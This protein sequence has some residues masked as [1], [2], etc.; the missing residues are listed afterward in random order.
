MLKKYIDQSLLSSLLVDATKAAVWVWNVQTGEVEFNERWAEIIGYTL[1]EL[2]PISINTWL[3]YSNEEDLKISNAALEDVFTHK[4]S[5]YCAEVRMRH[6][7]G[8]WVW[9]L[10][11]GKVL[12]WTDEGKPLIV[13]GTHIDITNQKEAQL[14][15]EKSEQNLSQIIENSINLIY[16][17]DLNGN[18]MYIS[19][20]WH[21]RM[22]HDV[23]ASIGSSFRPFIHPDDL[24]RVNSFFEVIKETRR[25]QELGKFRL[26]QNDGT[27]HYFEST[28][29]PIFEN[30]QVIGFSGIARDITE[31]VKTSTELTKKNEEL[32]R[33][34]TVSLDLLC[35]AD[36]NGFFYMLNIAWEK[37][38]G[39]SIEYLKSKPLMYF[40]HPDD[41]EYTTNE[42]KKILTTHSVTNKF[43][44]RYRCYDGTYRYLEWRSF[45][46][47]EFIYASAR[48]ITEEVEQ[49]RIIE[50]LSYHDQLTNLFNRHYLEKITKTVI[51]NENLPLGIIVIDIDGL[52]EINDKY[53][54]GKGDEILI[55]A[56]TIIKRNIPRVDYV[57]R[58]GGDEFVALVPC[59]D[60]Q[61]LAAIKANIQAD[62]DRSCNGDCHL[63]LSF[64]SHAVKSV[65]TELFKALKIA[66]D[67]MYADKQKKRAKA[68]N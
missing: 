4:T 33:F 9:V 50:H 58:M 42:M 25:H 64:G 3:K 26:L 24:P 63:S 39:Y 35:I 31:L 44:N 32:E 46:Y 27:W 48:D 34:F 53:G 49:K 19:S 41:V 51:K 60:E 57:F 29:S 55:N 14:R 61:E 47:K 6:K 23:N 45:P 28:A 18:F 20:T 2:K 43:V 40:V 54:H 13:A 16:R 8:S 11:N 38:L 1:E 62:I 52:K 7:N 10:D 5:H 67:D 15:A 65:E 37:T 66:D 56:A 68:H 22:G 59:T 21:K 30:E 17:I 12:E 36:I